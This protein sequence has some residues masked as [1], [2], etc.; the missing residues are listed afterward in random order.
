MLKI[1]KKNIIK[2]DLTQIKYVNVG[3]SN[4]NS[5]GTFFWDGEPSGNSLNRQV[6]EDL[7]VKVLKQIQIPIQTGDK[8]LADFNLEKIDYLS[9]TINGGEPEAVL[10]LRN[11]IERS[12]NIKV[13]MPGWYFRDGSRL[14]SVL[15]KILK[16]MN[17]SNIHNGKKGRVIA[18]K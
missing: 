10:G 5:K 1:L 2:N 13:T 6:L 14:D 17:F 3:V 11:T 8:I 7:N 9:I 18:W 12:N 16:D 4:F 15:I